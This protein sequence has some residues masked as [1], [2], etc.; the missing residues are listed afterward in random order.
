M[1]PTHD[2]EQAPTPHDDIPAS[3]EIPPGAT[4]DADD[5]QGRPEDAPGPSRRV[6]LRRSRD[7]KVIAGVAGGLGRYLGVDP[8]IIRVAFVV[9]AV[10]GALRAARGI[11][12]VCSGWAWCSPSRCWRARLSVPLSIRPSWDAASATSSSARQRDAAAG[13]LRT[14]RR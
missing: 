8:V 9:L 12:A 13:A 6:V 4:P 3:D 1:Q 14:R 2:P 7:D 5:W 11:G 10:S